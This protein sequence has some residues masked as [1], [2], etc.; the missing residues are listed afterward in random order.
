MKRLMLGW[1]LASVSLALDDSLSVLLQLLL[2]ESGS[3]RLLLP[4]SASYMGKGMN[5]TNLCIAD[6]LLLETGLAS[7]NL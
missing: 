3:A 6:N 2:A 1:W 5:D 4:A 7:L